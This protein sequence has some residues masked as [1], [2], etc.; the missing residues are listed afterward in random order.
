MHS[1]ADHGRTRRGLESRDV[2]TSTKESVSCSE[3]GNPSAA[4][5]LSTGCGES[6]VAEVELLAP[7]PVPARMVCRKARCLVHIMKNAK[8]QMPKPMSQEMRKF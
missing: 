1:T 3:F 6:Q 7:L 8:T 2:P 5:W 4:C